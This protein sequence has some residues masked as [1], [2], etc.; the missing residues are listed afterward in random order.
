MAPIFKSSGEFNVETSLV[1]GILISINDSY[2]HWRLL[3]RYTWSTMPV[4]LVRCFTDTHTVMKTRPPSINQTG[5]HSLR[6]ETCHFPCLNKSVPAPGV[7]YPPRRHTAF[8]FAVM[9]QEVTWQSWATTKTL[10]WSNIPNT[11]DSVSS[12]YLN[13]EKRVE[14]TT[15]S[16]VFLTN[17]EVF[18]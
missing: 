10:C 7:I 18:G 8:L 6:R 12:G 3:L 1:R 17:F 4:Q 16:G 2:F 14:N 11:R 13:T 5:A 9:V 15:R